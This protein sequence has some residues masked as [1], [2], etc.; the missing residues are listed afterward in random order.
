M[1]DEMKPVLPEVQD[2]TNMDSHNLSTFEANNKVIKEN[3]LHAGEDFFKIFSYPLLQGNAITALKNPDDVAISKKIAEEFFGSPEEAIG[4]TIRYQNKKDL[5][6]TGV[7]D[8]VPKNST[9]QFD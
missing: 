1:A 9:M 2:A 6:I 5:K 8:D 7:F 3:G 4:K